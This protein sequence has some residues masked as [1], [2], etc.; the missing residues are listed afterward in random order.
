[1]NGRQPIPVFLAVGLVL[2]IVKCV[3]SML[4]IGLGLLLFMG[5]VAAGSV[6]LLDEGHKEAIVGLSVV[7]IS[8]TALFV[9]LLVLQAIKLFVCLKAWSCERFWLILVLVLT[10]IGLVTE[11]P[12][13]YGCC[14]F[15]PFLVDVAILIGAVQ[16]LTRQEP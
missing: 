5:V 14:L 16:A 13:T 1:M 7:G 10:V 4:A 2:T 11:G 3:L 6:P 8:G 9:T 15:A 12:T